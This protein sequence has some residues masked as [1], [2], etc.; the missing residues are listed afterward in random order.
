MQFPDVATHI[1]A[2]VL[3][4][5]PPGKE[6][7]LTGNWLHTVMMR[8]YEKEVESTDER[9]TRNTTIG[10]V[11]FNF[12]NRDTPTNTLLNSPTNLINNNN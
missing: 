3:L 12:I 4:A 5:R 11:Y 1:G 10:N 2:R 8:F 7:R 9:T 6:G